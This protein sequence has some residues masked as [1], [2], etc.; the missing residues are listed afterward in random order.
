MEYNVMIT[1]VGGQGSVL[2]S[3]I[4]ANAAMFA[5][6]EVRTSDT[7]GMAQRGGSV[8][9]HVRFG[10]CIA[11]PLIANGNVD[12]LLGFELA[13]AVRGLKMLKPDG[14]AVVNEQVIVPPSV[15]AGISEYHEAEIKDFLEATVPHLHL[16]N[17]VQ[18]ARQAGHWKST[19]IVLIGALSQIEDFP[20][21]SD[22]LLESIIQTV[23][24]KMK[25]LNER[26][27]RMGIR[28]MEELKNGHK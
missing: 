27:F 18:I 20:L 26:A 2:A 10:D 17:A 1:G 25:E 12:I 5:G 4:V 6:Y 16:F 23:P 9:S 21:N 8:I 19:N 22:Q 3:R 28:H 15:Y 11:S 14:M 13:E 24:A 7:I